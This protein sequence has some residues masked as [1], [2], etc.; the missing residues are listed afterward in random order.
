VTPA[1]SYKPSVH[2][3]KTL[4]QNQ[5]TPD[6]SLTPHS[7]LN[8]SVHEQSLKHKKLSQPSLFLPLAKAGSK[9]T[10]DT[11]GPSLTAQTQKSEAR[12][13]SDQW[14][15]IEDRESNTHSAIDHSLAKDKF[16]LSSIFEAQKSD[17]HTV[18]D[19]SLT[20]DTSIPSSTVKT[21]K[22]QTNPINDPL[23]AIEGLKSDSQPLIDNSLTVRLPDEVLNQST[24][25]GVPEETRI[26]SN[27]SQTVPS[28]KEV[29]NLPHKQ[30]LT[31]KATTPS[32]IRT[33]I[34]SDPLV[35]HSVDGRIGAA[36]QFIFSEPKML[37]PQ[38]RLKST[39]PNEVETHQH[40]F[41]ERGSAIEPSSAQLQ[42]MTLTPQDEEYR[43]NLCFHSVPSP[44]NTDLSK[45]TMPNQQRS[46]NDKRLG[47]P[48]LEAG[49][50]DKKRR[51]I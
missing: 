40:Y 26:E 50:N 8:N 31:V 9:D 33:I 47:T 18:A 34:E 32:S 5:K 39:F 1:N 15:A 28:S 42:Y 16:S 25:A 30:S 27:T 44:D 24:T 41:P 19:H 36:K 13:A 43:I 3:T 23:L 20:N 49:E 6:S 2:Q 22:L 51:K 7:H 35:S 17:T 45:E 21:Q 10:K 29:R 11:S 46:G 4:S 38:Y 48:N 14:L 12:I 37:R